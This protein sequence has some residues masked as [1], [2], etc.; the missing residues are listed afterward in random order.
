[1]KE[2]NLLC[3]DLSFLAQNLRTILQL[4]LENKAIWTTAPANW[5]LFWWNTALLIGQQGLAARTAVSACVKLQKP[6][7]IIYRRG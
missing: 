7:V 2:N 5:A 4:T 1:M 6:Y 3:T